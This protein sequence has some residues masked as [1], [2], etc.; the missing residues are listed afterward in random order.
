METERK[1]ILC[2]QSSGILR[3][4]DADVSEEIVGSIFRVDK[5]DWLC[6]REECMFLQTSVITSGLTAP[7]SSTDDIITIRSA[8]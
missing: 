3:R 4:T 5:K 1:Q 6:D 2:F 7:K 8:L